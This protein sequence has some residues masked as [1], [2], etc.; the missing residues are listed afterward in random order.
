MIFSIF[1]KKANIE[2]AI[3]KRKCENHILGEFVKIREFILAIIF[4]IFSR[5]NDNFGLKLKILKI[6]DIGTRN[7]VNFNPLGLKLIFNPS[8][9]LSSHCRTLRPAIK[10]VSISNI[11][12]PEYKYC[13]NEI[14]LGVRQT[15][16]RW[17]FQVNKGQFCVIIVRY[18]RCVD[19]MNRHMSII[20]VNFLI[21]YEPVFYFYG[22]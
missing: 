18:T 19:I 13:K 3:S 21:P 20:T 12:L 22:S 6:F 10:F 2:M 15:R 16:G 11:W 14:L 5:K 9:L 8:R 4:V 1:T 7:K 17:T